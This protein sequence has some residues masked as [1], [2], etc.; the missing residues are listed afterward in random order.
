[1]ATA[2]V[3]VTARLQSQVSKRVLLTSTIRRRQACK[4]SPGVQLRRSLIAAGHLSMAAR[5][6]VASTRQT[7]WHRVRS[8]D[9]LVL[10]YEHWR[11]G[12]ISWQCSPTASVGCAGLASRCHRTPQPNGL[13][14][15]RSSDPNLDR[16]AGA[17]LERTDLD[18]LGDGRQYGEGL[19]S[20]PGC[21]PRI[22][23]AP[24]PG[25]LA[26]RR[27]VDPRTGDSSRRRNVVGICRRKPHP[28]GSA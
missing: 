27:L 22:H 7:H 12:Y 28:R 24:E 5:L 20:D 18:R 3:T 15:R 8:I 26:R 11:T 14:A 6:L 13:A 2:A 10:T 25:V 16:Q 17:R 19:L 21:G 4:L 1:S 9:V 23:S